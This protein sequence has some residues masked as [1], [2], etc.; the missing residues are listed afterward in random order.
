MP[1]IPLVLA[2]VTFA[3]LVAPRAALAPAPAAAADA[4]VVSPI[5]DPGPAADSLV[6]MIRRVHVYFRLHE[7]EGITMDSR[8]S[9][10]P[11]EAI[12]MGVVCQLLG[13]TELAKIRPRRMFQREIVNHAAFLVSRL[14]T[15]RSHGPFDATHAWKSWSIAMPR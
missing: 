7:Q 10:N 14:D 5:G 2:L 13:Y 4:A 9:V 8:Y 6:A 12:R 3:A 15:V 1:R 11:S